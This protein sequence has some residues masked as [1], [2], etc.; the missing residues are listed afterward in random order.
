VHDDFESGWHA[1]EDEEKRKR[2]KIRAEANESMLKAKK[3]ED[4][5]RKEQSRAE[6]E[7]VRTKTEIEENEK[8]KKAFTSLTPGR[9][10]AYILFFSSAKQ[11]AT[12]ISRIQ[13]CKTRILDGKGLAD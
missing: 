11:S 5:A 2:D 7:T 12:R 13:K 3:L 6:S 4:E 8:L 10:R 9:Q 1:Y